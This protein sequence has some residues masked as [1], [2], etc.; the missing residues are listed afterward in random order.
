MPVICSPIEWSSLPLGE[1]SRIYSDRGVAAFVKCVRTVMHHPAVIV[2]VVILP[3]N[4]LVFDKLFVEI[5]LLAALNLRCVNSHVG[6]TILAGLE[7][8]RT[9]YQAKV[10]TC[11]CCS[12]PITRE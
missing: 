6:I 7:R 10:T 3:E 9:H 11:R 8:I 12:S 4:G 5:V 1:F 2:V